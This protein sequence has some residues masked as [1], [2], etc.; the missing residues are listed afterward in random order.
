MARGQRYYEEQER[1]REEYRRV[2]AALLAIIDCP[3]VEP[4]DR[5]RAAELVV[6]IDEAGGIIEKSR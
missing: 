3:K 4:A 6:M 5:L 2:R 1:I